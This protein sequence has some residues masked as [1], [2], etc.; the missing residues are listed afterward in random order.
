MNSTRRFSLRFSSVSLLAMGLLGPQAF[1]W[2]RAGGM[3]MRRW[4]RCRRLRGWRFEPSPPAPFS[5]FFLASPA[6][7]GAQSRDDRKRAF[8]AVTKT[9]ATG[10]RPSPGKRPYK[11]AF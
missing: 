10:P 6:K 3:E 4:W 2:I 7:A 11:N 1:V 8:R 9:C 5:F